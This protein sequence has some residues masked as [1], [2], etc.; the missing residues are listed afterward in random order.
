MPKKIIICDDEE[1]TREALKLILGNHY[2]LILVND[3]RQCLEVIKNAKDIGLILLDMKMPKVNGLS[4]LEEI[5]ASH[6]ALPVVMM[7]GYRSA[8]T[9]AEAAP[10]GPGDF[11]SKPFKSDDILATVK[12]NFR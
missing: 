7:T 4:V 11:L 1:G 6:S 9:A 2:D 3:G 5:K 12:R 8:E 10:I